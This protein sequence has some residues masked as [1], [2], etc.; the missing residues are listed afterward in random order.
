MEKIMLEN[1]EGG[2]TLGIVAHRDDHLVYAGTL[3]KLT[4]EYGMKHYEMVLTNNHLGQSVNGNGTDHSEVIAETRDAEY[5]AAAKY[6]GINEP[7]RLNEPDSGLQYSCGLRDEAARVIRR[8]QP[9]ILFILSQHCRH[10]DHMQAHEIG[11]EGAIFAAFNERLELGESHR[12]SLVLAVPMMLPQENTVVVDVTKYRKG[13]LA[14]RAHYGS[15]VGPELNAILDGKLGVGG[16][17]V[18]RKG[19]LAADMF[20]LPSRFPSLLFEGRRP[21]V[22]RNGH[23]QESGIR[24]YIQPH[25]AQI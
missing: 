22:S 13:I 16:E 23:S 9:D 18:Q 24:T 12:T 21:T 4:T 3:L 6:L 15:Q 11:L 25:L 14:A 20:Y 2:K 10:R 1:F 19:T 8:V 7:V 5:A 17:Q